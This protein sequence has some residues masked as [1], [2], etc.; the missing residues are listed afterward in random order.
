MTLPDPTRDPAYA[1]ALLRRASVLQA[2][3]SAVVARL[4][5]L[6][7]LQASDGLARH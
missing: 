5:L 1:A 2:E 4:D 7:M 3:A 6:G